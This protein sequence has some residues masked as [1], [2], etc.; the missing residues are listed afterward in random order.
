METAAAKIKKTLLFGGDLLILYLSFWLALYLRYGFD[1]EHIKPSFSNQHFF[2]FTIIFL[3]WLL[4][5]YI[6]GLYDLNI[7]RN[8]LA[9]YSTLVKA[10]LI[11]TAIA[12]SFFY[13]IA[14]F[15]ITPKTILF[16]G[17]II[18]V[19]FLISWRQI[20]N[21][22]LVSPALL[23]NLLIIGEAEEIKE[24]TDH[25]KENPQLGFNIKR[26][27]KPKD[28]ELIFNLTECLVQDNIQTVVTAINPHKN[29]K[30]VKNL[31]HCLPLNIAF[32]DLPTFYEKIAGKV[33]ISAIEEIWFLE[34]LMQE[35]KDFYETTKRFLDIFYA[36]IIGIITLPL[37]PLVAL[38]IKI[39]SR[40]PVFYK[41][42]RVGANNQIFNIYKFRSMVENAEKDGA[43]W[44][45]AKDHRVTKI[46]R[47]LRMARIDELPQ[48]YNVL[49]G[50]MSS[51]GP[52]PERPEFVFGVNLQ[53]KIPF[54]QIRHLVKP[55]LTG[56]AQI[57]FEYGASLEDSIEKLEYDLYYIKNRS[58]ILDL[59]I[60]LRTIKIV[61][62]GGGR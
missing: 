31:Y 62:S 20:F 39:D 45:R 29:G 51:V 15:G 12:V 24:L 23:N 28:I 5:F 57:N 54:Y 58:F 35:K 27:V 6:I 11:N 10:L 36:L 9:F 13:F 38:A 40:G 46:G 33:P 2:P 43:Q 61:L 44:A 49:R 7:A 26:I 41:Q 42:K 60:I 50:D 22:L 25:I 17:I 37:Y 48:L 19:M 21:R 16:L 8:N 4:V 59:G 34:N 53:R 30:L 18:F 14:Y 55:G 3:V 47:L 52:R 56:W 32:Y 1:F